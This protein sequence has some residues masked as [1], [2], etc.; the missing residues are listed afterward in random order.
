MHASVLLEAKQNVRIAKISYQSALKRKG[1]RD[2]IKI[3]LSSN[4]TRSRT[5]H[6]QNF[7]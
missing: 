1:K 5:K 2:E 6:L 3:T 4:Q 7:V